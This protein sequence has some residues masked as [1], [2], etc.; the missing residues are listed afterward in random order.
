MKPLNQMSRIGINL[1][2]GLEMPTKIEECLPELS[3]EL[4]SLLLEVGEP[5]LAASVSELTLVD[6]CPCGGNFCAGFYTQPVPTGGF[7]PGHRNVVLNPAT[8]EIYLDVVHD[9][10]CFVECLDRDE[11]RLIL[12]QLMPLVS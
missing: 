8:G 2:K 1:T 11:I 12:D 7:G 9:R 4:V 5:S 6:R 10:I 3:N